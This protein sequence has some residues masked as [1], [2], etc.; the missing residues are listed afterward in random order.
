MQE[1]FWHKR[2]ENNQI[3]FH[4]IKPNPFLIEYFSALNVKPHA[5]IFVPLS[6]KTLDISWLLAQGCRVVAIELSQIAVDALIEQL[7]LQFEIST[8][9]T[10]THYYHPQIEIFSGDFFQLSEAQLGSVNA[11]YD[12]AALV[13]LPENMRSQYAQHL[14]KITHTAPQFLISYEYDQTLFE[15]PPFCVNR[16]EVERLY[17]KDYCLKILFS[18][19]SAQHF[20]NIEVQDTVWSLSPHTK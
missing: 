20:N 10:L 1:E 8:S 7:G 4:Q 9:G 14:I 16:A 5:R 17:A 15:G 11:I 13:A 6:G 19:S 3:G 18:S 12:R 2:W